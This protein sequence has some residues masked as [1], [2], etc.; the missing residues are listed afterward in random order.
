LWL[1]V[2]GDAD[3]VIPAQGVLD[4]ARSLQPPPDIKVLAG[5]SHFFHGR[6]IELREVVR[7]WI[8]G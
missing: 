1:V 6:L 7:D 3:E 8:A 4:W 5:A 2:Q